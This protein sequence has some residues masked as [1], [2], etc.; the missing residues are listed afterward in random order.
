MTLNEATAILAEAGVPD[1]LHDA[2][3]IFRHY[4]DFSEADLLLRRAESDNEELKSAVGRR[5]L[6]EPLQYILY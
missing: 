4:G 1:A 6:R 3:E 5:A 2:R